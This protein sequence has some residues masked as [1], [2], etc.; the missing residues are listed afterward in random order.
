MKA[1]LEA[2]NLL[3]SQINYVNAHGTSTENNDLIESIA[4]LKL[5]ENAPLFL[6]QKPTQGT[7][8]VQQ[9]R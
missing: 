5:F 7:H 6:L 2:A 3:P 8:L 4:M 9:Q 1:A